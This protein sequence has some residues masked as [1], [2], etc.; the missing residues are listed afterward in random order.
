MFGDGFF[1]LRFLFVSV[2]LSCGF[3]RTAGAQ[4]PLV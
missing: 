4:V 3:G 1:F 2:A